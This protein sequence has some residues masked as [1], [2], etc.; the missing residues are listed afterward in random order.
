MEQTLLHLGRIQRFSVDDGPGIRT[1]VFLR[2]CNLRCRWC[3]NPENLSTVPV[4]QYKEDTCLLCG[5]CAAV[6]LEGAHIFKSSMHTIDRTACVHCG[7]CETVCP[8]KTLELIGRRAQA[9]EILDIVKRDM[10]FYKFS[11]GGVTFSGGDPM[12]QADALRE[13]LRACKELGIHTAVDTAGC[14]PF[15]AFEKVLPYTDLFLFDIKCIDATLHKAYT[16]VSNELILENAQKLD[17]C[18]ANIWIRTPVIPGFNDDAEEQSM[19][20]EF[21][22]SLLHVKRHDKLPYHDY[23][24]GKYRMIG[25]DAEIF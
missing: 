13:V 12:L 15:E 4:L 9:A 3:H 16:G 17:A 20:D 7:K 24:V 25:M 14:I 10:D 22:R 23:G 1:T 8:N 6:C 19:I 2:G 18:G 21:V 5:H 11:G